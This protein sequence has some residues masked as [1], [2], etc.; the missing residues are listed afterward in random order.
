MYAILIANEAVE[1]RINDILNGILCKLDAGVE[2]LKDLRCIRLIG[3]LYKI[4]A[5]FLS[6]R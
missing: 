5:K 2:D 3:G 4:L 6:N 1:S